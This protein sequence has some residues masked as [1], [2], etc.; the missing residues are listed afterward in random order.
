MVFVNFGLKAVDLFVRGPQ[1]LAETLHSL[2][3]DLSSVLTSGTASDGLFARRDRRRMTAT[4]GIDDMGRL[5]F[6]HEFQ[7]DVAD[8]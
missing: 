5:G 4:T 2:F 1:R 6:R 8:R 7:F 3:V